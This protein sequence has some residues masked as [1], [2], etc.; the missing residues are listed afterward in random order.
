MLE[1]LGKT[2]VITG[3]QIPIFE[4]RT[5][6]KDNFLSSLIIAGNYIIPEVCVFFGTKLYR[7]NRTIKVSSAALDAFDTPNFPNLAKVG[8][9]LEI[10]Y[11]LIYRPCSVAKFTVHTNLNENVGLLRIFPSITLPTVKAFFQPPMKGVVLQTFGSGNIPSN[12]QDLVDE[13]RRATENGILIVNCTQCTEGSVRE[14]YDTGRLLNECGV[15]G[16]YDM[17]PEAALTKLSYVLSKDE[18]SFETKQKMMQSNLRGELTSGKA[19]EMQDYDLVDAVARSLHLSTPNE[20]S[21]LGNTL[22]PAMV[23]SSVQAGDIGK[24]D[25]LKGYGADLSAINYDRRTALHIASAEGNVDMVRHL[26][27]NGAAVHIRDRYDRTPLLEA[28]SNDHHDIIKLLMKCGA[29]ITGSARAV[30]E[31]LCA[32]ASR[33]SRKRLESYYLAGADLSQPDPSGRTALHVVSLQFFLK[34]NSSDYIT[35]Y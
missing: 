17:T 25:V 3:S 12:R 21:Q 4:T 18:W 13:F 7:G 14:L 1:N 34:L 24:V 5:D 8:I 19:P 10:D 29:H 15:I 22:F 28:I 31:H 30:G 32:A 35:I 9:F 11:R 16:G 6:G 23:N 2:V 27:L 33:G 20:L 26:L